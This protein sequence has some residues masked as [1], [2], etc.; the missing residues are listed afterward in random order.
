PISTSVVMLDGMVSG[1]GHMGAAEPPSSP[2]GQ[3]VSRKVAANRLMIRFKMESLLENARAGRGK[4]E[5]E[6]IHVVTQ[7][8][9]PPRELT[10][11]SHSPERSNPTGKAH[12]LLHLLPCLP[13]RWTSE[14]PPGVNS[15]RGRSCRGA[16]G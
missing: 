7:S 16:L 5:P 1:S 3:A 12:T 8:C 11:Q 14:T 2:P 15:G 4:G 10:I 13:S 6:G 9:V